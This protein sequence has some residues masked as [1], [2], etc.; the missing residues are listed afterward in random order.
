[1]RTIAEVRRICA[2]RRSYEAVRFRGI[3]TL[4][5][6][7]F[8]LAVVE[9]ATGGIRVRPSQLLPNGLV[10]HSVEVRGHSTYEAGLDMVSDALIRDLGAVKLP[11]P[12]RL[13][14]PDLES[15]NVDGT[16]VTVA[17]VVQS[18]TVAA[19]GM[20]AYRLDVDGVE[21]NARFADDL[22]PLSNS[23][24]DADVEITGVAHTGVDIDGAVTS[25]ALDFVYPNTVKV[26][27]NPG[28]P[29]NTPVWTVAEMRDERRPLPQHRIRVRGAICLVAKGSGFEFAD[30][31]GHIPIRAAAG[32]DL[33]VAGAIEAVAFV[34]RV[35][36]ELLLDRASIVRSGGVSKTSAVQRKLLTSIADVRKLSPEEART[37][38]PVALDGVITYYSARWQNLFF[39]DSS[40]GIYVMTYSSEGALSVRMGDH[41]SLTGVTGPGDFAPVIDKANFRVLGQAALPAPSRMPIDEIFDGRA[42]SQWVELEGVIRSS[43]VVGGRRTLTLAFGPYV[44]TVQLPDENAIPEAWIDARVR[45]RGPCGAQFNARRQLLGI[46]L[47][48]SGLDQFTILDP[49]GGE[50][51]ALPVSPAVALLRFAPQERSGH[52]VRLR[53]TVSYAQPAGQTWIQDATGV[54][55]IRDHNRLD[56][57]P[58]DLVDVAGFSHTRR[59]QSGR[60]QR[61]GS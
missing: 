24:V 35:G 27:K 36:Q 52:R 17:G 50:P 4:A 42:D 12:R 51:F 18:A 20:L 40:A 6:G 37:E 54:V 13:R 45:V 25:F 33:A 30:S 11:T 8:D 9:D 56:L 49:S 47:Y 44:F 16:L 3:V 7:V 29:R 43:T 14:R 23:P 38:R 60:S 5:D 48:A 1:M 59:H 31:T 15:D 21:V 46:I 41:V 55:C 61:S 57:A 39:Q 19:T 32:V 53:G 22:Q 28:N 2:E 34:R 26:I 10:G 58:G